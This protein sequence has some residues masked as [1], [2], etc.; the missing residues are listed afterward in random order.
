MSARST[1]AH[2]ASS[3]PSRA[4]Q[5]MSKRGSVS[6]ASWLG[7]PTLAEAARKCSGSA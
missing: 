4:S 7:A 5:F 1:S 6:D 3:P 2:V